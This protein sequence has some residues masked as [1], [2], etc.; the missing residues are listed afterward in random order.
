MRLIRKNRIR[1]FCI[2]TV[3]SLLINAG[4]G[5]ET[6]YAKILSDTRK[7]EEDER[8]KAEASKTKERQNTQEH[9]PPRR[10]RRRQKKEERS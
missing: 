8:K 9:R 7:E 6:V 10:K 5:S 1:I 2:V 3:I 4:I